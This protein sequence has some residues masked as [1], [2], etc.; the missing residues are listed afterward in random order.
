MGKTFLF[1]PAFPLKFHHSISLIF[2]GTFPY[3]C[4]RLHVVGACFYSTKKFSVPS[5]LASLEECRWVSSND[6][7]KRFHWETLQNKEIS[8]PRKSHSL[9]FNPRAIRMWAP[10]KLKLNHQQLGGNWTLFSVLFCSYSILLRC[11]LQKTPIYLTN[12]TDEVSCRKQCVCRCQQS[13]HQ[14]WSLKN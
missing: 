13:Q 14:Q 4:S 6:A 11:L 3:E 2:N 1:F 12:R 10:K 9:T 8:K 7:E 5:S